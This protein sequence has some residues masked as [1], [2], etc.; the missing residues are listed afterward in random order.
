LIDEGTISIFPDIFAVGQETLLN[1]TVKAS[2]SVLYTDKIV[3]CSGIQAKHGNVLCG[4]KAEFLHVKPGC[5]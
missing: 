2:E 3:V 1:V 5:A 4:Q